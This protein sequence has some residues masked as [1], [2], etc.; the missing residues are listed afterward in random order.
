MSVGLFA[1]VFET[2][3]GILFDLA[4]DGAVFEPEKYFLV[5]AHHRGY[6]VMLIAS[7]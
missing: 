7:F 5:I 4:A 2:K 6:N 1:K 3:N